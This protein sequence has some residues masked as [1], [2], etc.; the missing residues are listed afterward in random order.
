MPDGPQATPFTTF[1]FKVDLTLE[2]QSR[3]L[4][5]AA[6]AECDGLEISMQPKTYQEG[7][8][9]ASQVH[10]VGPV[11]YGQLSLK[12]GMTDSFDLWKWFDRVM[13]DGGHGLRA[14]CVVTMMASDRGADQAQFELTRCLPVKLKAPGLNAKEGLIAIEEMQIA[15]E[16]LRIVAPSGNTSGITITATATATATIG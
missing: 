2:G 6:F 15:Y 9:N 3:P 16:R 14:R 10:L 7:G 8:N 5:G 1:N 12:R 13:Q 4:C 11:S